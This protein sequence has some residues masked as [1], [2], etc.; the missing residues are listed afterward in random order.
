MKFTFIGQYEQ[1]LIYETLYT[2]H[3]SVDTQKKNVV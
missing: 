3:K 1:H 2:I